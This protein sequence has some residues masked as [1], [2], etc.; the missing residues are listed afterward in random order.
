MTQA[1]LPPLARWATSAIVM[2]LLV[3]AGCT[4]ASM[5]KDFTLKALPED[6]EYCLDAER[7]VVHTA[8][9]MQLQLRPDFDAFVKSKA[10]IEGPTIQQYN[11]VDPAGGL[12]GISCKLK[13]ADHLELVYGKGSAGPEG[14]CQDMNRAVY[15][16]VSRQVA[17]PAYSGVVFDPGET[18][19]NEQEP[20]MTGPDWLAPFTL[21]SVD[22]DGALRIFSKG[23]V[24]KFS[25]PRFASMPERFRGVHYCHF[26]APSHLRDLLEGKARPGA[27]I[28]RQVAQAPPADA[29]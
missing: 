23:F 4:A 21:T 11:W 15:Q 26:I 1:Q 18:V 10:L 19:V 24:V 27:V 16:L 8:V 2:G 7:V 5:K 22:P 3:L 29:R 12:L 6:D 20:G 28:G 25:D 13:N 17:A 14:S 9:L